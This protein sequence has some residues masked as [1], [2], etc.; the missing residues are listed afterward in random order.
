MIIG[1]IWL[2]GGLIGALLVSWAA[3]DNGLPPVLFILLLVVGPFSVL[4]GLV[5]CFSVWIDG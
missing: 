5:L 2:L 4:I 3:F 1:L